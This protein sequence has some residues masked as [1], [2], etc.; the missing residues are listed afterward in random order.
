MEPGGEPF[1]QHI[2]PDPARTLGAIASGKAGPDPD[3]KHL[4]IL[5]QT[6]RRAVEAGMEA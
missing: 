3:G 5:G 6:A 1:G 2:V 4:V